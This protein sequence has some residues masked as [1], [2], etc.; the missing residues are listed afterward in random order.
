MDPINALE[1]AFAR[2][3]EI[4]A[5]ITPEQMSAP[6]PCSE[7]DVA[8]VLGHATG[9]VA[10]FSGAVGGTAAAEGASFGEVAAGAMEGWR[11]FDLNSTMDF[12]QPGTPGVAVAGI[13]LM[14]I[15]GHAWDLAKAT[16]QS[17]DLGAEL[18]DAAMAAAQM[19]VSDELREGRFDAA[20]DA[21][22]ASVS[23]QFAAFLGRQP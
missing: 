18:A 11:T 6:T 15:C 21:P 14:D 20:I 1:A 10:A 7:W 9:A 2:T 5:N 23:D 12:P 4:V 3:G 19:I 16:G 13:Q 8:E 17:T 22:G